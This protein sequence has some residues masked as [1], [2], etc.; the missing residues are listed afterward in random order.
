MAK[1]INME[2]E[3]TFERLRELVDDPDRLLFHMMPPVGWLNDPNGLCYFKDTYHVFFQYAP[4]SPLGGPKIWG[5]YASK[6]LLHWDFCGEAIVPSVEFD[7]GAILS[8]STLVEGGKMY[9]Y[10]TGLAFDPALPKEERMKTSQTST[11]CAVSEDSYHYAEK[12]RIT[13]QSEYPS[14]YT[15]HIRDPKVWK[16]DGKYYMLLGSR[17]VDDIGGMLFYSG[18]DPLHLTL[19]KEITTKEPFGFMW[20]CPD[21]F[22]IDGTQILC[23]SPQGV[24]RGEYSFQN[25]Y[26]AGYFVLI[27]DIR[28]DFDFGAFREWDYGFDFYAPQTFEDGNG[29]R[30]L[31]GWA[32]VSDAQKEY[33]NPSVEKGWQHALTVPREVTFR[34]GICY[35][36]PVEELKALQS[37]EAIPVANGQILLSERCFDLELSSLAGRE[38]T[39]MIGDG[40]KLAFADGVF[41]LSMTSEAGQGRTCRK[42]RAREIRELK[43]LADTTLLE[44]FVNHGESVFT[45]RYYV[46]EQT[47]DVD[48]KDGNETV[49][50]NIWMIA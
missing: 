12:Y 47:V 33:A 26:A 14:Y 29:R 50:G 16:M 30:I 43:V 22:L 10:Y 28:E 15:R 46:K 39:I 7:S 13:H 24:A 49:F 5:H 34:D 25:T 19:A 35:Q 27:G 48:I 20:E 37:G 40:V 9:S 18:D 3:T 36:Y 4:S 41:S 1:Y 8:G 17:N 38:F 2:H 32:S 31:I 6:D 11:V 21:W 45:S 42:I 23:M 44:I